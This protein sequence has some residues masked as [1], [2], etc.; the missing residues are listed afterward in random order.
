VRHPAPELG[1]HTAEVLRAAGFDDAEIARLRR[2]T[3]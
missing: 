2:E 3:P 1:A